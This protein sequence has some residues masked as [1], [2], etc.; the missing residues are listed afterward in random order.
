MPT[1]KVNKKLEKFL[2]TNKQIKVAVGGRDS[3]KSIGFG[4]ML[5]LKMDTEGADI[6]C[7]REFQDSISDSVHRVFKGS[8]EDRLKLEGWTITN[9]RVEA[10]NG[11]VTKYKGAARNTDSIQ[12]AQGYKYSWFEEAHTTPTRSFH[13]ETLG[14]S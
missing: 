12:S 14:S 9:D 4:D 5:T 2:T 13:L 6:Y 1:L 3:G 11:A 7:L 10:P 8:I